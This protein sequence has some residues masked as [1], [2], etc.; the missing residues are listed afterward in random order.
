MPAVVITAGR[1]MMN[2]AAKSRDRV[3]IVEKY[4][5]RRPACILGIQ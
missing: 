5:K 1:E 4:L 3:V 2:A